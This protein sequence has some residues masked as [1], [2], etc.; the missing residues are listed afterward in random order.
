MR[1]QQEVQR[2]MK[3]VESIQR[4]SW[5]RSDIEFSTLSRFNPFQ[6][7]LQHLLGMREYD[8]SPAVSYPS[9]T[10]LML[11]GRTLL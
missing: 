4:R 2:P 3:R 6:E 5:T 10:I 7:Y 1:A 8:E 11:R 9:E